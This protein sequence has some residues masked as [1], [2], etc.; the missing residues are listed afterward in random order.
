M[1]N[2]GENKVNSPLVRG[3]AVQARDYFQNG[4]FPSSHHREDG[5][6]FRS[7]GQGTP[8]R[9]RRQGGFAPFLGDAAT[10]PRGDARRGIHS[11][12]N[13]TPNHISLSQPRWTRLS[14][15]PQP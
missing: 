4:E 9:R 14:T 2:G 5:V 13:E 7:M 10:P 8:P 15:T 11:F 12:Q 3:T 1:T 6:V